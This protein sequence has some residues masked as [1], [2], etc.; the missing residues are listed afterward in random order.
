MLKKLFG[1]GKKKTIR[2]FQDFPDDTSFLRTCEMLHPGDFKT[3]ETRVGHVLEVQALEDNVQ[4]C[5]ILVPLLGQQPLTITTGTRLDGNKVSKPPLEKGDFVLWFIHS[6]MEGGRVMQETN[7]PRGDYI[8][9]ISAKISRRL[10]LN[11]K[12]FEIL[13]NYMK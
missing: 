7:D 6:H 3:K 8:G 10:D 4:A 12:K 5:R 11:K 2:G 9:V 13:V 1:I